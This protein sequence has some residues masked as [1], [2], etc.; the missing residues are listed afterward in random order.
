MI[1]LGKTLLKKRKR[2][3]LLH[4]NILSAALQGRGSWIEEFWPKAIRSERSSP[5]VEQP[6]SGRNRSGQ[7]AVYSFR[8]V[9]CFEL[10][11]FNK[12]RPRKFL[13]VLVCT[14]I[15]WNLFTG[16]YSLV[17]GGSVQ[18]D[19]AS[20]CK[21]SSSFNTN[22]GSGRILRHHRRVGRKCTRF[23]ERIF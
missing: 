6:K 21:I 2:N 17:A 10:R 19:D 23:S 5:S 14:P 11:K 4:F 7:F 20:G 3:R 8:C 12:R 1:L 18:G 22:F 16:T 13:L 15:H 9:Q